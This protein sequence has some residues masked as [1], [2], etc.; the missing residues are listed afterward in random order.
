M[1]PPA[2]LVR[3]FGTPG[4]SETGFHGT[5]EYHFEDNNLDVFN[6]Y[7]YK[8]TDF[9]HGFNREDDFYTNKENMAKKPHA[10]KR[11]W[12]SIEEF[13]A[14]EEPVEFK[15][16]ATDQSE[17]RKFRKWLMKT[18]KKS[19]QR[20]D[21]YHFDA[22]VQ[23]RF[24]KEFDICFGDYNEKGVINTSM[25]VHKW[26]FTY[27][28]TADE[29]KALKDKKPEPVIPPKFFDLDKAERVYITREELK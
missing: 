2:L 8:K 1:I 6:L 9:F 16:G 24:G 15:L 26:D 29:I 23:E 10:R 27:H 17:W 7:D 4:P 13:W 22:D 11:K 20:T 19:S 3:T 28:M 14:S 25:A 21:G 12:P 18:L 5:G